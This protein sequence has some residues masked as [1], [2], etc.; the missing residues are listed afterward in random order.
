[1]KGRRDSKR[2]H[3]LD[4]GEDV[5]DATYSL[6][7]VRTG[8]PRATPM[9]VTVTVNQA[10][11]RIEVD[12]GASASVIGEETYN[13]LWGTKDT[14]PLRS[15]TVT[16]RTYTGEKLN[17]LGTISVDVQYQEQREQ[18]NLLVVAGSGPSLLGRDWLMAIQVDWASLN[19]LQPAPSM[20]LHDVLNRHSEVFKDELG[21]VIGMTAKIHVDPQAQSR[22]CKAR[23]VPYALRGKV[24]Q[25]LERLEQ[26]GIVTPVQF[27]NWATPIVPVVKGD[28]SIRICGDYKVTVNRAARLDT[29]PLPRFG[30]L[31]AALGRGKTFTKLDLAHAYQQI[32]LEEE[33]KEYATINTHKGLYRYNRLPFGVASAPSIFQRTMEG[34]LR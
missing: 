20:K 32:A 30:D 13:Q 11:L 27:S 14:P 28:G 25:E 7:N 22:F 1:M 26:D 12:T 15:T 4:D 21:L 24:E 17:I 31:F 5:E 29:Y 6:F 2:N 3:H 33:S 9:T 16:L 23:S 19:R 34:I 18:L 8:K 10:E